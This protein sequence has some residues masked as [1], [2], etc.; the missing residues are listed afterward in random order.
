MSSKKDKFSAK[1]RLYMTLAKNL[2]KQNIGITNENPSVGCVIV[3]NNK[4][5]S[6]STTNQSGRPHAET[7]A[8]KR[9]KESVK[10][11]TVYLTL[12]PCS[13]FGKTPPCTK[14]LIRS[15][16]KKVIYSIN[17]PDDRTTNKAKFKFKQHK[18]KTYSGLMNSDINRIYSKYIY[19]KTNK[20]PYVTG[21]IA[22][23][24]NYRFFY[25]NI[26]LT[27]SHSQSVSHLLRYYNQAIITS[28]KTINSDNPRL[29]CRLNGLKKFSPI[30]II[31]DR[32][33]KS[34]L[35]MNIFNKNHSNK[36]IVF[37]KSKNKQKINKFKN[38]GC[39]LYK[40]V[41]NFNYN[42]FLI[43]VLKKI[44][45]LKINTVLVECGKLL[46]AEFINK[47]LINE[48][49]LFKGNKK[50]ELSKESILNITKKLDKNYKKKM[51]DT[52]VSND[53]IIKYY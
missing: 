20:M 28:Y 13:H 44:Y 30:V 3:K 48:F 18:I 51:V 53:R 43:S 2:A 38:T 45:L 33:L 25:N 8:I 22:C 35:K 19:C 39:R 10:G 12:E 15:K 52:F 5:I 29:T 40:I 4:I 16:V 14:A 41:E 24:K 36:L 32:N 26:K 46:T 34:N 6:Y 27:N 23:T 11:S 17:D 49:Y 37:H 50:S 21:K 47:G 1:D 7:L 42:D 31:I 9:A